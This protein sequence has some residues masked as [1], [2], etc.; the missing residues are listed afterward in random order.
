MGK[1]VTFSP[2]EQAAWSDYFANIGRPTRKR[3]RYRN[4]FTEPAKPWKP[5]P[6]RKKAIATIKE[7][8]ND[9]EQ[10]TCRAYG[11]S[12]LV[13]GFRTLCKPHAWAHVTRGHA[14]LPS[15][16]M[17]R[18][19]QHDQDGDDLIRCF[20]TIKAASSHKIVMR[21]AAKIAK[22]AAHAENKRLIRQ[23]SEVKK[24]IINNRLCYL[25]GRRPRI[26]E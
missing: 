26:S 14:L 22:M 16:P 18:H 20:Q 1:G 8:V 23:S 17:K 4:K 12:K 7:R 3:H 13:K 10:R 9:N 21:A 5:T 19:R 24:V 2:E 15:V 25:T 6:T 11:C